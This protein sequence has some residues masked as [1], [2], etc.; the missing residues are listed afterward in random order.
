M[1]KELFC[2]A[3]L[4]FLTRSQLQQA[5]KR[6]FHLERTP[7]GYHRDC[8]FPIDGAQ[9]DTCAPLLSCELA[10]AQLPRPACFASRRSPAQQ[11]FPDRYT[12]AA[13]QAR[14]LSTSSP[15]AQLV[16][17]ASCSVSFPRA[18]L[19]LSLLQVALY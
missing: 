14:A 1:R 6:A 10:S 12:V 15:E 13:R 11:H 5:V 8:S 7:F 19:S 2:V 17:S 3:M 9:D 16:R 4:H 18:L